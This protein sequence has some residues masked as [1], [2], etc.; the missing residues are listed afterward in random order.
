[1]NMYGETGKEQWATES[2]SS[3]LSRI[4][5]GYREFSAFPG[6]AVNTAAALSDSYFV[7]LC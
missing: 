4:R 3:W 1:M 2:V 5:R 6:L 7:S